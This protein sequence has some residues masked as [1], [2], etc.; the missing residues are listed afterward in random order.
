MMIGL[1]RGGSPAPVGRTQREGV[2]MH[3]SRFFF[4]SLLVLDSMGYIMTLA[5]LLTGPR[6]NARQ[7]GTRNE[8]REDVADSKRKVRR[9]R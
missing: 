3:H 5:T 1:R 4:L 7:A 6:E 8:W 2:I 9:A